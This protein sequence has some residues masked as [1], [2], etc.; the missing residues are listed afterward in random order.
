[1]TDFK[2]G[3]FE[4]A[5]K[6]N[7]YAEVVAQLAKAAESNPAASVSFPVD[8]NKVATERIKFG[9][10]ANK[11]DKTAKL[12]NQDKSGVTV[13]GK[14]EDGNDVLTGDVI[15]TFTI[16]KRQKPR[17]GKKIVETI[18]SPDKATK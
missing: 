2:F 17:R 13:A 11:I 5:E 3:T 6:A 16:G 4:K 9:Q 14:D 7:P 8:V 12:V 18:E 1:M 10:A 15:L